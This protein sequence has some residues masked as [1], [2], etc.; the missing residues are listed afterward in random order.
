MEANPKIE[1][2]VAA[3]VALA[4]FARRRHRRGDPLRRGPWPGLVCEKF[5]DDEYF[6]VASPR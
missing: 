2:N 3:S 5:L 1:V 4:D 6:P